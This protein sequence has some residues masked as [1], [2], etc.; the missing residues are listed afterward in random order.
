MEDLYTLSVKRFA[1]RYLMGKG[2]AADCAQT[3][4]A[5]L[6]TKDEIRMVFAAAPSQIEFLSALTELLDTEFS[7]ISAFHMDEYI[8]LS[9]DMSQSFSYFLNQHLFLKKQF[10]SVAYLNGCAEDLDAECDRY[11]RLLL[12]KPIDIVCMGIGE[13]GHIAFNDPHVADFADTATV[14]CVTLDPVCRAQQVHDGCFQKLDDVPFNAL[15]LTLP[16]IINAS[17]HFCMVPSVRK[18]NAVKQAIYGPIH[19]DCPASM[20]RLCKNA[21]LYTDE[22]SGKYL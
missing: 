10:R 14:K 4:R 16:A 7:K 22:Y 13:N 3:I 15:T 11:S 17:Y 8:G 21:I 20:L 2:A 18:A 5:L 12:E 19:S 9:P 1:N 6:K